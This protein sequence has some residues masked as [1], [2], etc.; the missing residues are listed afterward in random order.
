MTVKI[1]ISYKDDMLRIA[2]KLHSDI[3]PK[4]K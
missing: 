1:L 2:S 4:F 3:D